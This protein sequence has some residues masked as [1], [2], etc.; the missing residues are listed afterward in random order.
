MHLVATESSSTGHIIVQK[1][2]RTS[3]SCLEGTFLNLEE[4]EHKNL[5][6]VD[7]LQSFLVACK[8]IHDSYT[9]S[10]VEI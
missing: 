5:G 3:I 6:I 2:H 8:A 10:T 4:T 7:V 1:M 9:I